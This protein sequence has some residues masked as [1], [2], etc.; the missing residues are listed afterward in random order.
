MR[1]FSE[2]GEYVV[3]W[4]VYVKISIDAEHWC[5]EQFGR[6]WGERRSIGFNA[7]SGLNKYHFVF[8]RLNHAQWFMMKFG[9]N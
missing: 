6:G 9:S 8:K 3:E 2:Q 1:F 4:F 5:F 7:N